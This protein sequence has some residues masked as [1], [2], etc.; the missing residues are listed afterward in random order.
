MNIR[1]MYIVRL[2]KQRRITTFP[3][4]CFSHWRSTFSKPGEVSQLI[5]IQSSGCKDHEDR[6][7]EVMADVLGSDLVVLRHSGSTR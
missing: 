7:S 4:K 5:Y 2:K 1:H 3:S 6:A